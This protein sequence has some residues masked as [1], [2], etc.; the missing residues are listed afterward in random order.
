[1]KIQ[2][3]R[4]TVK[5]HVFVSIFSLEFTAVRWEGLGRETKSLS[6]ETLSKQSSTYPTREKVE[7]ARLLMSQIV[8]YYNL[9]LGLCDYEIV[10]TKPAP[11]S[12]AI[13]EQSKNRAALFKLLA[14]KRGKSYFV[15]R[16]ETLNPLAQIGRVGLAVLAAPLALPGCTPEDR[17]APSH[18]ADAGDLGD[19]ADSSDFSDVVDAADSRDLPDVVDAGSDS[20]VPDV[21]DATQLVAFVR[22][23]FTPLGTSLSLFDPNRDALIQNGDGTE[24]NFVSGHGDTIVERYPASVMG[25]NKLLLVN[26][27]NAGGSVQVLDPYSQ[28]ANDPIEFGEVINHNTFT[29]FGISTNDFNSSKICIGIVSIKIKII[30]S[31]TRN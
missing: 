21:E 23:D 7:K 20:D 26:R 13:H 11:Q 15:N 5:R 19:V 4:A 1:M 17:A 16:R 3:G 25:V 6:Q 8:P 31:C 22:S 18:N 2:H 29:D 10:E 24:F 9:D 28:N 27:F 12:S 30:D 14:E